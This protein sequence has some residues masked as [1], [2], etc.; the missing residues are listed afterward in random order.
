MSEDEP[1]DK[2]NKKDEIKDEHR[3][4][5]IAAHLMGFTGL[6]VPFGNILG[7]FVIW[8]L[9]KEESSF[10]EEHSRES[11]NFQISM[12]IYLFISFVLMI[13]LVGFLIAFFLVLAWLALVIQAS[14]KASNRE[15]YR[16][17]LTVRFIGEPSNN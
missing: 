14:I 5:A 7:P 16:Y 8:L 3:Q 11:L 9:K 15:T 2:S 4:W 12:T 17:P 13:V 6:F 10:V 1:N